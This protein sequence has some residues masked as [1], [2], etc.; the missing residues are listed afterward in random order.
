MQFTF[1]F[2]TSLLTLYKVKGAIVS[3]WSVIDE[4]SV[5]CGHGVQREVR[6]CISKDRNER[7]LCEKRMNRVRQ[8]LCTR[9]PCDHGSGLGCYSIKHKSNQYTNE[10][11]NEEAFTS[12]I[13]HKSCVQHC[14]ER[15]YK[16]AAIQFIPSGFP[17][18]FSCGCGDFF[19]RDGA[20]REGKC[21]IRCSSTPQ[22]FC[23]GIGYNSVFMTASRNRYPGTYGPWHWKGQCSGGCGEVGRRLY[24]RTCDVPGTC[25]PKIRNVTYTKCQGKCERFILSPNQFWSPTEARSYC[26]GKGGELVY[27]G[28]WSGMDFGVSEFYSA[29]DFAKYTLKRR[30]VQHYDYGFFW[31]DMI[32]NNVDNSV[33][34]KS[35]VVPYV[36]WFPQDPVRRDD[37]K[38]IAVAFV[39]DHQQAG[40]FQPE[41]MTNMGS[42]GIR[43]YALCIFPENKRIKK[44]NA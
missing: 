28:A 7:T 13:N 8:T 3:Q 6:E 26:Q 23:G 9:A 40:P 10:V 24:I 35:G 38:Y 42:N 18:S 33:I 16:F 19:I 27:F 21:N 14:Q 2:C 17:G 4:C 36:Q 1:L 22:E 25:H 30:R 11:I 31:T 39:E 29:I 44:V 32:Y 41:W 34:L 37:H 5:T 20:V 12:T 43:A 15:G